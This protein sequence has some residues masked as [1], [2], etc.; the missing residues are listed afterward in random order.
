MISTVKKHGSRIGHADIPSRAFLFI[1]KKCRKFLLPL[2]NSY[3]SS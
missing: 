1:F 3:F 2:K